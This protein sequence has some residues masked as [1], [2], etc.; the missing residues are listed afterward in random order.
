[1]SP[2]TTNDLKRI[3]Q[4]LDMNGDDQVSL[5]E[6]SWLL[7]RIGVQFSQ[8]ELESFV[9]KPS[10]NLDEFLFFYESISK[11]S[12]NNEDEYNE[13]D[14]DEVEVEVE[15][16]IIDIVKVFKVFDQNDDRFIS[17]EELQRVLIRL[18]LMVEN[19]DRDCKSMIN[20]FDAN[21]DG[22]LD[23]EEFKSMMLHTSS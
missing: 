3:F 12:G 6:L 18:G 4:K 16:I 1:M 20:A 19:S 23:F 14:Q 7:E 15:E 5:E 17:C 13:K 21:F 9:G 2:L 22:K 10:L 11:H 8:T